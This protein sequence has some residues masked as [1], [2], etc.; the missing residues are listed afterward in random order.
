MESPQPN[1]I[2]RPRSVAEIIGEALEIY[3]RYPLLFMALAL[4]VIAPYELAVLAATGSSSLASGRHGSAGV[5]LLLSL[6]D[7]AL[8]GP[9]ISALHI[10]AVALIGEGKR[11][12][13]NEVAL[14]GLR[15][16]PVV[17]AAVI[18]ADAGIALGL[19]AFIIPGILLALRWSVVAQVAA[20]DHEGWLPSLARSRQLTSGHYWHILGLLVVTVLLTAGIELGARAIPAG[21]SAG[22]VSVLLAVSVHTIRASFLALTLAILYF[23]LRARMAGAPPEPGLS[24]S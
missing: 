13:L 11:P 16:L 21:S 1:P 9:L 18:A 24:R 20:V 4:G 8:V 12:R 22:V 17:A 2:E 23:D 3:Q 7:F 10:H 6:F 14:R 5:S 15:V 19:I